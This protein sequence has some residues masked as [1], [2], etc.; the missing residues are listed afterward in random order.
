MKVVENRGVSDFWDAPDH[1]L[2]NQVI[3]SLVINKS[4]AWLEWKRH[5][6]DE[7]P[8]RKIGRRCLYQ[9]SD[10]VAFINQHALVASTSEYQTQTV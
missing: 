1:A 6:G 4:Q 8:F 5:S 3:I 7:I 2:F 10:V 9:K